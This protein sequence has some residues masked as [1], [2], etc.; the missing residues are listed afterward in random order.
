MWDRVLIALGQAAADDPEIKRIYGDAI[1]L[2]GTTSHAVPKLEFSL[3]SDVER[4]QWEPVVIQWDQWVATMDE[5]RASE[6][7]LRELF[8]PELPV[9][10]AGIEMD[11][12]YVDSDMLASPDRDNYLG[13]AV[14]FRHEVLRELY[15]N[16]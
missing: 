5:L 9:T 3:V 11:S 7:R 4:E 6:R 16:P 13:R 10:V 8:N 15:A 1:K 12:E 2:A 14:R